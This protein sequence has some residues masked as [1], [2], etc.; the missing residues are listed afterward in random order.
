MP[1]S[2]RALPLLLSLLACAD[3]GDVDVTGTTDDPAVAEDT[4]SVATEVDLSE[5]VVPEVADWEGATLI[6]LD[7]D[8][9]VVDGP[10]AAA[11]GSL[12]TITAAGTYEI[13]GTLTDGQVRVDTADDGLVRLALAGAAITHRAGSAIAVLSAEDVE[14]FLLDGTENTVADGEAYD[15]PDGEDEPNAA[16]FSKSDLRIAGSGALSVTGAYNDGIASKDDLE[17]T[18]GAITILAADDGVRG[19]DSVTISGGAI[20]ITAGGDGISADNDEDADQ[21]LV[22]GTGGAARID[23][24]GDGITATTLAEISG[25]SW[26]ITAGGGHQRTVAASAS[27]KGIKALE[28]AITGGE[29]DIDAAEDGLHADADLF[30][31]GGITSVAAGDDGA[32]AETTATV[33]GGVLTVRASY[34]GLESATITIDDGELYLTADD[35]GVNVAGGADGSGGGG[36]GA[37]ASGDWMLTINGGYTVVRAQGDGLDSNGSIEMTGGVALVHGPTANNNGPMDMGESGATFVISG[38]VLIASGSSGMAVAPTSGSTQRAVLVNLSAGQAA[39]AL[40]H[41]E[42][43]AGIEVLTFA[44]EK[45]WQSVL[46]SSPDLGAGDHEVWIGGSSTGTPTDGWYDGGI[47]TPGTLNTT[48][49]AT[50][51]TTTVGQSG[52]PGRP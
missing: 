40:F 17:I 5:A 18:N 10:G 46:F 1:R 3:T 7:G 8:Q 43:A 30:V 14:I 36:W 38:G 39:G 41:L 49:T 4:D 22:F 28:V 33:S 26:A 25:G 6:T 32:H 42:T 12:V 37:A 48:F 15:L 21:G 44:P 34:E 23:A 20:T 52:R 51:T 47:Y 19:K 45:A 11:D 50:S 27:A 2:T 16:I 24:D 13:R 35:D 29:L 9:I 31:S